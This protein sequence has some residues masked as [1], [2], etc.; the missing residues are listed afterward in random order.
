MTTSIKFNSGIN[1]VCFNSQQSFSKLLSSY[2][3]KINSISAINN[4]IIKTTIVLSIAGTNS[5]IGSVTECE[6]NKGYN[7]SCSDSFTLSF[8]K[9]YVNEAQIK[10]INGNNLIGIS[11]LPDTSINNLF[12][13]SKI[14]SVS[15]F[16]NGSINSS[17]YISGLGM[18]GTLQNLNNHEGYM[19][20]TN[21]SITIDLYKDSTINMSINYVKSNTNDDILL[22]VYK[23]N[24]TIEDSL[25]IT[26]IP[27][28]PVKKNNYPEPC[29]TCIHPESRIVGGYPIDHANTLLI[30]NFEYRFTVSIH[31]STSGHWCGGSILNNKWILSAAHCWSGRSKS[32]IT[33]Y[34]G[35]INRT[36]MSSSSAA[37]K[38][39][40]VD[41]LII[42]DGYVSAST[43]KDIALLKVSGEIDLTDSE[44]TTI[45]LATQEDV[46]EGKLN[47]GT[48]C[49]TMGWGKTSYGGSSPDKL[50]YVDMKITKN[51]DSYGSTA[52]KDDMIIAGKLDTADADGDG[53]TDDTIGGSDACQGDSGGPLI[54][55]S[56]GKP[57]LIGVTSWGNGCAWAGYPGV[58]A[59]VPV[60]YSWITHKIKTDI[61]TNLVRS[62]NLTSN[63]IQNFSLAHGVYNFTFEHVCK[64]GH[65]DGCGSN[66]GT[67]TLKIGDSVITS[68]TNREDENTISAY[69]RYDSTFITNSLTFVDYVLNLETK[70]KNLNELFPN[71][72]EYESIGKSQ[73]GNYDIWALRIG[74]N[75]SSK[76]NRPHLRYIANM[77][78]NEPS[79]RPLLMWFAEFLCEEYYEGNSRVV[80]LLNNS[81]IH[82]IPSMNPWG[83]NQTTRNRYNSRGIDL[84]RDFPDQYK[85]PNKTVNDVEAETR[86]L[87]NYTTTHRN[88]ILSANYHEGAFIFSYPYDGAVHGN[89]GIT[90]TANDAPD[91]YLYFCKKYTQYMNSPLTS[92]N[93]Y[94]A[95]QDFGIINGADWYTLFGGMQDWEYVYNDIMSITIETSLAKNRS[96][97]T[98]YDMRKRH[99]TSNDSSVID[100][101]GMLKFLEQGYQG[102]HGHV[103]DINN[104][105][106]DSAVIQLYRSST[107]YGRSIKSKEKGDFYKMAPPGSYTINISKTGYTTYTNT[108]TIKD[109]HENI[110][111]VTTLNVTLT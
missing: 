78:G 14:S 96:A 40:L 106:I 61:S 51:S 52:I 109:I 80:K 17:V 111:K 100:G 60:Y 11:N 66:L 3:S 53:E 71:I 20:S 92:S 1:L 24:A 57:K 23:A 9:N 44:I 62:F 85:Y 68:D 18:V 93:S 81:I 50:R 38:R 30:N 33:I 35:L 29:E 107:A 73:D 65:T 16:K 58:W 104:L 108:I 79:G 99:L 8:N 48:T 32:D 83:F 64:G 43:G 88:T 47:S 94:P 37:N 87:M 76:L 89:S 63:V 36:N 12:N 42:L 95:S 97:F 15:R 19:V 90:G 41:E 49:Y 56:N 5:L 98:L 22:K 21:D 70:I 75:L 102:I 72:T 84:N 91:S 74:S 69:L 13:N 110:S 10:L 25:V 77:H 7:V 82:L 67:Y 31:L 34:A 45:E 54:I 55:I 39:Y 2:L 28:L 101:G 26:R 105:A 46:T 6:F 86:H 103:Y 4:N 59:S 27:E